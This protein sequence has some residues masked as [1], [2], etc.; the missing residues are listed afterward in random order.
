WYGELITRNILGSALTRTGRLPQARAEF[1]AALGIASVH[2][3]RDAEGTVL[4]NLAMA[5]ASGGARQ[6]AAEYFRRALRLLPEG[7]IAVEARQA[8]VELGEPEDPARATV[9]S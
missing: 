1:T 6:Q 5:E 3:D 9:A 2:D 4:V 7:P 8:L